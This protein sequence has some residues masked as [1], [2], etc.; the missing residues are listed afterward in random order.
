MSKLRGN[1]DEIDVFRRN[2]KPKQRIVGR[3]R[4]RT[5]YRSVPFRSIRYVSKP[6]QNS[7]W[8]LKMPPPGETEGQRR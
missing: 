8:E 1:A 7:P 5:P 6:E 3:V 2:R 4:L